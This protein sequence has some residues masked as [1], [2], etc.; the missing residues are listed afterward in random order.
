MLETP[1]KVVLLFDAEVDEFMSIR[2]PTSQTR[3][4]VWI[5]HPTEPDEVIIAAG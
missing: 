5:N 1:N 2:V 3:I 4:R